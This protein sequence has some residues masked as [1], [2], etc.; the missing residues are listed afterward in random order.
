MDPGPPLLGKI[1]HKCALLR[2]QLNQLIP[3]ELVSSLQLSHE[4]ISMVS[5]NTNTVNTS[6]DDEDVTTGQK[7][8]GALQIGPQKKSCVILLY[9]CVGT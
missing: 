4:T 6:V 9:T 7:R 1:G 3:L 5:T 8:S 2:R